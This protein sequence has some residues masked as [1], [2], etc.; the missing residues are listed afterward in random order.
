MAASIPE[1][2]ARIGAAIRAAA[3][4]AQRDAQSVRLIAV[5][6]THPAA[7]IRVAHAAGQC[8]FGENYLQEALDKMAQLQDLPL[9]WHF[10]GPIQSNKTRALASHFDW[11]HTV[12][13]T[14]IAQRLSDQRPPERGP[15][16]VL[17]QVNISAEASKSGCSL[18]ELPALADVVA[19]LP[20][21]Q[22]CGLM[23]IPAPEAEPVRQHAVFQQVAE[24]AAALRAAGHPHCTELSMGM[25]ADFPAAIAAGATM[26]RIGTDLF[27]SRGQVS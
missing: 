1:N 18:A 17:L 27:G 24:A 13:R 5:S 4:A 23:A 9:V 19:R 15:L 21:L 26:V 3:A 22:L 8:E 25:S 6:K 12:D 14:K 16:K 10:I 7:S 11:V 20:N 2:L